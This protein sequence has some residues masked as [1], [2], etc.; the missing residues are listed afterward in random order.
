MLHI[1]WLSFITFTAEIQQTAN[2]MLLLLPPREPWH[3]CTLVGCLYTSGNT[4][5]SVRCLDVRPE[6]GVGRLSHLLAEILTFLYLTFSKLSGIHMSPTVQI[7][8][9]LPPVCLIY[10]KGVGSSN[11]EHLMVL[12]PLWRVQEY[13][14]SD[15]SEKFSLYSLF[16]LMELNSQEE[17]I[18]LD[19][20][21]DM[22]VY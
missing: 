1:Y 22:I 6:C 9:L 15:V 14:V 19:N 11:W 20:Y 2:V 18:L 4:C 5:D 7:S 17:I 16:C 12:N 8:F 3:S 10:E 21:I 13:K